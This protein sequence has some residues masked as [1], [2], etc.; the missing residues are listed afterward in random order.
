MNTRPTARG[1]E[2]AEGQE[3]RDRNEDVVVEL[4]RGV[5]ATKGWI[6]EPDEALVGELRRLYRAN[7][8]CQVEVRFTGDAFRDMC[9]G[10]PGEYLAAAWEGEQQDRWEREEAERWSCPCGETFGL[11]P[12]GLKKT[13]FYTLGD[14]GLFGEQ[15][16][17]C[18]RCR[19]N[20]AETR[21]TV[22]AGQL[23]FTV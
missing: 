7:P 18:P 22:A 16:S 4:A 23:G 12:F 5:L 8:I 17:E 9:A 14:N 3:G 13:L 20:L 1:G 10:R 11:Y 21:E 15:V 6:E 19:R 2:K